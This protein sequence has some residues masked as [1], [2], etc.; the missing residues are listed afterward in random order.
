MNQPKIKLILIDLRNTYPDQ[1]NPFRVKSIT[2]TIDFKVND[3]LTTDT[4]KNLLETRKDI[5]IKLIE[6]N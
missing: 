6:N 1:K 4:V 3:Y 5:E 2:N